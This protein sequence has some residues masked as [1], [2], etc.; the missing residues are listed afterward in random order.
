MFFTLSLILAVPFAST[1]YN[2]VRRAAV[3]VGQATETTSVPDYFQITPALF[4]G[5]RF[6]HCSNDILTRE[7]PTATGSAPFL[8]E[9]NPAPFELGRTFIANSP[10]EVYE[11]IS[12]EPANASIFQL[13]GNLSPYFPNPD[14]Q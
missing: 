2:G 9:T 8:A 6:S 12:G 13:M 7:G 11:P 10:L 14:P 1:T 4:Q 3:A 5:N